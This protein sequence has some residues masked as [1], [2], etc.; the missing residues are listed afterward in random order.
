M[1]SDGIQGGGCGIEGGE[2]LLMSNGGTYARTGR[3]L[4][5]LMV[6]ASSAPGSRRHVELY[7]F[8][9]L[10]EIRGIDFLGETLT[11]GLIL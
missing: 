11:V 6:A 2:L 3:K 1:D 7:V 10:A 8:P 9:L 4:D 5:S